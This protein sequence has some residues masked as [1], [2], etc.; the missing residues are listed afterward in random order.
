MKFLIP[1]ALLAGQAVNADVLV[2]RNGD[3]ITGN[4]KRIW[5]KELSVKPKYA[6]EFN[7]DISAIEH[8]ESSRHFE[9]DLKDGRSL[10]AQFSGADSDG[11][12]LIRVGDETFPIELQ[13]LFELNEPD[14]DIEWDSNVEFSASLNSGNTDSENAKLRADTTVKLTDHR[15]IGE[16]TFIRESQDSATTKEQDL[17]KY[18]YNW[19]FR[20][21]WFLLAQLSFERDP[22]IE[23]ENR[24]ILSAG[25]GRDIWNTPRRS[26][27]AQLGAGAQ[28]EKIALQTSENAV[29]T[30]ALRYR[31]DFFSEDMEL[32]HNNSIT[33][34]ISGRT[35]TSYKTTTGLRFEV[36]DLLYANFSIDYDYETHPVDTAENED[37]AVLVGVGLEF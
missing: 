32:Y 10:V 33:S 25:F 22:I 16:I 12:Q 27:S 23:L 26:L 4:I 13:A 28:T 2:L 17:F 36:T 24:V 37:V 31:Q 29:L 11:R 20:D 8:I 14:E 15:H 18:T 5:D 6:D 21:P 1:A 7:V 9:I 19:L 35:N 30:W 3:R 34:N